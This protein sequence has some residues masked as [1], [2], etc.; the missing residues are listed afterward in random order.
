MNELSF[1]I[2]VFV[3]MNILPFASA[4]T[5][6]P[7]GIQG[8]EIGTTKPCGSNIGACEAGERICTG[9]VWEDVCMGGNGPVDEICGNSLDDDCNGEV[10]DCYFEFP[11]P[12]WVLVALGGLL[13]IGAWVYEKITVVKEEELHQE[14]EAGE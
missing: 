11:I 13:L 9:G 6:I 14:E 8:C 3:I 12:G 1:L 4:Q 5:D 7:E 10:D 2:S